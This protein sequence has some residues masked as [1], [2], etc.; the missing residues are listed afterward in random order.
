MRWSPNP[1]SGGSAWT[2]WSRPAFRLSGRPG[3]GPAGRG[4]PGMAVPA[5]SQESRASPPGAGPGPGPLPVV[6]GRAGAGRGLGRT[7]AGLDSSRP[8]LAGELPDEAGPPSLPTRLD[9]REGRGRAHRRGGRIERRGRALPRSISPSARSSPGNCARR[10]P[11]GRSGS[12]TRH[13]RGPG[14]S[15]CTSG[16]PR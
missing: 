4:G 6:A 12:R 5:S 10:F 7:L 8:R 16:W 9:D 15:T 11:A 14:S 2:S 13:D 1:S 3:D